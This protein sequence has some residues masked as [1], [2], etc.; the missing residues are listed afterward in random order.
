MQDHALDPTDIKLPWRQKFGWA[1]G[2]FAQTLIYTKISTYLVASG[3]AT[4]NGVT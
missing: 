2:D 3:N 4:L 1:T